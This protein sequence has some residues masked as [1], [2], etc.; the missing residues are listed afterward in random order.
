MNGNPISPS[1]TYNRDCL[2]VR[3]SISTTWCR[4]LEGRTASELGVRKDYGE[5]RWITAG[6]LKGRIVVIV[7]TPQGDDAVRIIS[8]RHC[9]EREAREWEAAMGGSR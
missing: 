8:I 3:G 2:L 6:N 5:P 9:H 7:W 4:S 1:L